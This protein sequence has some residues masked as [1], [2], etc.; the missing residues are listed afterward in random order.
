[1]R[2]EQPLQTFVED[3]S[4]DPASFASWLGDIVALGGEVTA[5]SVLSAYAAGTFPME[6][7]LADS[8]AG[9][10]DCPC[11]ECAADG[12]ADGGAR[13]DAEAD[14]RSASH[15]EEAGDEGDAEPEAETM[16]AWWSPVQRGVL[17]LPAL[18]VSRSLAK[19][20][21]RYHVTIDQDFAEVL[22]EC[23]D[24][25]DNAVWILDDF[26]EAYEQ[27]HRSG[28]A[29]SIE[30]RDDAGR[31][32]GGLIC[33]EQGGLVNGDSMFHRERDA[34]KVALVELV[35]ILRAAPAVPGL[36]PWLGG[37]VLD[38]QWLT[39]HLA[40]LGAVEISRRDYVHLLPAALGAAPAIGR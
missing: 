25:R 16:L 4:A 17:P 40:S 10:D 15:D 31:L 37:R 32:V 20:C 8:D 18:R 24:P 1:M 33:V 12:P 3:L 38:V 5:A 28:H 13:G 26:V 27:L 2:V 21:R 22:R 36:P 11:D 30:A 35:R 14:G 23:A 9:D 34:S 39:P 19:S 29:H 6:I 7:G